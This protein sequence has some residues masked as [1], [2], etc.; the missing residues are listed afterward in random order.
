MN[1]ALAYFVR[2]RSDSPRPEAVSHMATLVEEYRRLAAYGQTCLGSGR[3]ERAG[4]REYE[5]PI[6]AEPL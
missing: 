3:L 6:D 2:H 4:F 5:H 1:E